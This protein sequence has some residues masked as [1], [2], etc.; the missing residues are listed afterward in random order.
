MPV[1]DTEGFSFAELEE[2]RKLLVMRRLDAGLWDWPCVRDSLG[3][4]AQSRHARPIGF[5]PGLNGCHATPT[6]CAGR[7]EREPEY[8]RNGENRATSAHWSTRTSSLLQILGEHG[9]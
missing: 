7:V 3:R 9:T 2:A 6:V 4:A 5:V 1:A 8:G